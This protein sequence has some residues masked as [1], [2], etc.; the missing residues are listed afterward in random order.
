M[1][2]CLLRFHLLV[3]TF[4]HMLQLLVHLVF[5]IDAFP[6]F[7]DSALLRGFLFAV[8]IIKIYKIDNPSEKVSQK[9]L[10]NIHI[11]WISAWSPPLST[12]AE[13]NNT[14]TKEFFIHICRPPPALIHIL[15]KVWGNPKKWVP[16][17]WQK[18]YRVMKLLK[19]MQWQQPMVQMIGL[20]M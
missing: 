16:L 13:V 7:L 5:F 18:Y 11:L 15:I 1:F 14:H 9:K 6:V 17:P 10:K 2:I 20:H 12:L 4:S 3:Y 8:S 19:F